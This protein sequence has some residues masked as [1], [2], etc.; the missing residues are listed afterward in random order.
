MKL[1]CKHRRQNHRLIVVLAFAIL[2]PSLLMAEGRPGFYS[3][4]FSSFERNHYDV[5][6]DSFLADTASTGNSTGLRCTGSE[7]TTAQFTS[8]SDMDQYGL[9]IAFFTPHVNRLSFGLSANS[10]DWSGSSSQ[11]TWAGL[12]TRY[13]T[14]HAV[15]LMVSGSYLLSDVSMITASFSQDR[16]ASAVECH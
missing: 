12:D 16:S 14:N 6:F 3:P 15:S 4:E 5:S 9:G 10:T 7:C 11:D 1:S 8:S 2:A 13:D